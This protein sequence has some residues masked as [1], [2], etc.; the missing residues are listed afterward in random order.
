MTQ[1]YTQQS[2]K[3]RKTGAHIAYEPEVGG[4]VWGG[5]QAGVQRGS[6]QYHVI[7]A[8]HGHITDQAQRRAQNH[9]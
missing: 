5:R 4:R 6:T 1:A 2:N 7:G 9:R 3:S 8:V